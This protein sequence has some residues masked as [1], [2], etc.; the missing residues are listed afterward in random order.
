[1]I[2]C[3]CGHLPVSEIS[4][5]ALQLAPLCGGL[6]REKVVYIHAIIMHCCVVVCTI[7]WPFVHVCVIVA[8]GI[9]GFP[10]I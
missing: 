9:V 4:D 1:M 10:F 2:D 7:V 3:F 8:R 5:S 6:A